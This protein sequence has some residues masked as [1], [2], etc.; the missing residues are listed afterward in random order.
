[1]SGCTDTNDPVTH[2]AH[3][4][5]DDFKCSKCG[6]CIECIDV[7]S[8]MPFCLGNAVKYLWRWQHKGGLE[9]IKKA[10]WYLERHISDMEKRDSKGDF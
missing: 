4:T 7:T 10:R 6:E 1:M 3:Y 2:P 5:N 9:D 8:K